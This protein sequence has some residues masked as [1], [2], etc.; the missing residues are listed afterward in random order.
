LED[1]EIKRLFE[2]AWYDSRLLSLVL[3]E[4]CLHIEGHS[5]RRKAQ[6]KGYRISFDA[7]LISHV[8]AW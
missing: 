6:A 3:V 4:F 5:E 8:V 2:K 7:L 1:N